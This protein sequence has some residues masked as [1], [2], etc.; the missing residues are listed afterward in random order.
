MGRLKTELNFFGLNVL[1]IFL[2]YHENYFYYNLMI[3]FQ[4]LADVV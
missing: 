4:Q 3:F 2:I 1:L